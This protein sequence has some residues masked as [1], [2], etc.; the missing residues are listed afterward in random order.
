[1]EESSSKREAKAGRLSPGAWEVWQRAGRR[2][3]LPAGLRALS[4]P[5]TLGTKKVSRSWELGV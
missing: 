4:R 2:A 3:L 5:G 1:M